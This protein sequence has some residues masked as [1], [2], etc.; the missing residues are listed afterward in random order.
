MKFSLDVRHW[1][2]KEL[3]IA[4]FNNDDQEGEKKSD[5][6]PRLYVLPRLSV[7]VRI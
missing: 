1:K 4:A 7:L 2:G 5:C 6:S 3:L